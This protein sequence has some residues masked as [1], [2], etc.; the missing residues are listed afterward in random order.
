MRYATTARTRAG[1]F[2]FDR[3]SIGRDA[4]IRT[5]DPLTPSQVRYQAALHPV[6]ESLILL[7]FPAACSFA[8]VALPPKVAPMTRGVRT[9]DYVHGFTIY[10]A[11][12]SFEAIGRTELVVRIHEIAALAACVI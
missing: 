2:A 9:E 10:S 11:F 12:G 5:R 1:P 6:S 8:C 7:R 4:G 3:L